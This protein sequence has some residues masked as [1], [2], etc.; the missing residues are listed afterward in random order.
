[1]TLFGA[2][3]DCQMVK[4]ISVQMLSDFSHFSNEHS[5]AS[6]ILVTH[7]AHQFDCIN[8]EYYQFIEGP[9][10][11]SCLIFINLLHNTKRIKK[12]IIQIYGNKQMAILPLLPILCIC[13]NL[14]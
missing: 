8:T 4:S 10:E 6:L 1:M 5:D 3:N 11:E 12:K 13:E 2:F 14:D 9:L 7:T